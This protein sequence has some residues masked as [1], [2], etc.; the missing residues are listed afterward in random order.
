MHNYSSIS[1]KKKFKKEGNLKII[2]YKY[3]YYISHI[4]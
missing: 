1:Y 4:L 2:L 3:L